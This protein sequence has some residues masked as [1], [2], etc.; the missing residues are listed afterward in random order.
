[1]RNREAGSRDCLIASEKL[2]PLSGPL[3]FVKSSHHK[4]IN[5]IRRV[6]T[7]KKRPCQIFIYFSVSVLFTGPPPLILIPGLILL[8]QRDVFI[9]D[10]FTWITLY[11]I[12]SSIVHRTSVFFFIAFSR[13][14]ISQNKILLSISE[15]AGSEQIWTTCLYLPINNVNNDKKITSHVNGSWPRSKGISV[16]VNRLLQNHSKLKSITVMNQRKLVGNMNNDGSVRFGGGVVWKNGGLSSWV[17]SKAIINRKFRS[18]VQALTVRV[19]TVWVPLPASCTTI[20]LVENN[21]Q[22]KK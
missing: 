19:I 22:N 20:K 15:S 7:Q 18:S 2:D 21:S 17:L 10:F 14:Q 5:C 6:A 1:M 13:C 8:D 9:A 16:N 4:S 3:S 11:S 12:Q